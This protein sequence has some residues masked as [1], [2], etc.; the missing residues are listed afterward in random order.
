MFRLGVNDAIAERL[1]VFA[2]GFVERYR[3]KSGN[4]LV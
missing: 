1:A 4:E 2:N 3:A